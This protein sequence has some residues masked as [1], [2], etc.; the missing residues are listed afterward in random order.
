MDFDF[1]NDYSSS[2]YDCISDEEIEHM[3]KYQRDN[4]EN[5]QNLKKQISP[6]RKRSIGK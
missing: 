2:D 6:A 4:L 1:I 5:F 3:Q